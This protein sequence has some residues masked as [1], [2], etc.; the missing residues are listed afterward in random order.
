LAR[1]L[2]PDPHERYSDAAGLIADLNELLQVRVMPAGWLPRVF[3][4]LAECLV[5]ATILTTMTGGGD[6]PSVLLLI[7]S[8]S[9]GY[10]AAFEII[11]GGTP[12]RRL[13]RLQLT[14]FSGDPCPLVDRLTRTRRRT[15]RRARF[16]FAVRTL[17]RCILR[18]GLFLPFVVFF[19]ESV[20]IIRL[21]GGDPNSTLSETTVSETLAIAVT[22]GFFAPFFG[23][24]AL[25]S[26][27]LLV[28]ARI[29]IYDLVTQIT[30]TRRVRTRVGSER[31]ESASDSRPRGGE[32]VSAFSE[33]YVDQ[34]EVFALIGAGGMGSVYRARDRLLGREVA[35]KVLSSPSEPGSVA[36]LWQLASSDA[37]DR[38]CAGDFVEV[39][40]FR[41]EARLTAQLSHPNIARVYGTGRWTDRPYIAMEYIDG[42]NL[43]ELVR[44]RG[45]IRIEDAWRYIIQAA[46]AL[47]EADRLGIIHR[48]IKPP[49]LMLTR[50]GTIKVTDFGISR[51]VQA[52]VSLTRTGTLIGTPMFMS[53]EQASG[54]E[55]DRRSDIY[56]LGMTLYYLLSGR[57]PFEGGNPME[58]VARQL[59]EA[60]PALE[61]QVPGLTE[62]RA[63]ILNRMMAK[64]KADRYPDYDTLL[65][66]LHAESPAEVE[67][68]GPA[69]RIIAELINWGILAVT[70]TVI[71]MI[72]AVYLATPT[73]RAVAGSVALCT[74]LI[75]F[76]A[77][78]CWAIG[79]RGMTP[80]KRAV[81]IR[82]TR[83]HGSRV[84]VARAALRFLVTYPH[85]VAVLIDSMCSAIFG[86]PFELF[87]WRFFWT[88]TVVL[89]SLFL[90]F[91]WRHPQRRALHDLVAGTVVIRL[92]PREKHG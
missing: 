29:P 55:L 14:D 85:V 38:A 4:V 64:D 57:P 34:Y 12:M 3:S 60:P 75:G 19:V 82:V 30:L 43:Q 23:V 2:S 48:D 50:Q 40:R 44:R 28:G 83:M 58:L 32:T 53:P 25:Y 89:G 91:V 74:L 31:T 56:S 52:D 69:D 26:T 41:R 1:C 79:R 73:A 51:R 5:I 22:L 18:F 61:G 90:L 15:R 47:R 35:L 63:R 88:A 67:F 9:V 86:P 68:A 65:A 80:G 20:R 59:T 71:L 77:V 70:S 87:G 62:E 42:P 66:D 8:L 39:E 45:A 84:G 81:G 10:F 21:L 78:Y 17:L 72:T 6:S 37:P 54:R 16:A 76:A 92:P 27:A 24:V 49:N 33:S 46:E 36:S 7:F 11:A 13:A